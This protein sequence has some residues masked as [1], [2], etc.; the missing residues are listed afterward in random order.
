MNR[1]E[2]HERIARLTSA[3]LDGLASKE[4][5]AELNDRLR[6]DPDACE[7][8]LDLVETHAA[9]LHGHAGD[10]VA[11]Q[12]AA[13]V[14]LPKPK[15]EPRRRNGQGRTAWL[16]LAAS[17]VFL[18]AALSALW[19]NGRPSGVPAGTGEPTTE[20]GIAVL[21]RL[22]EPEWPEPALAH[23]EGATLV[24]GRFSLRSGLAQVEFFSGASLIVEGPAELELVDAWLVSCRSGRLR[25]SVP[26]PARGFTIET[27]DYR[28]VDLGTEF[29]L[30]VDH[31]GRSEVHVIEGEV[32]LDDHTGGE[33]RRLLT[34][35]GVR[36][37]ND[38]SGFEAVGRGGIDF[39]SRRELLTLAEDD[40]RARH[41]AWTRSR[42]QWN[43][44]SAP[45]A[46]FDFEGQDP[47]DRQLVN[48]ATDGADGAIIGAPWT[49]GR[50]PG[51][52]ALEFKRITDRVRVRIPGEFD[53]LT[54][55]TSVRIEGLDRWLSSLLLTDGFDPGEVHWQIS[56]EGELILGIA[57][58]EPEI[59]SFSPSVIAPRDL[60]RWMHL[61][62][63]I[64]RGNGLVRHY[65]DGEV[66][67]ERVFD[68]L[69]PLRI[70]DAEIGN[71]RPEDSARTHSIRSF[72]GR[73]DEL[74]IF[75]RGLTAEEIAGLAGKSPR[76]ELA[77]R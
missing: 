43:A 69:P 64:D 15:T 28:A 68:R 30:A 72:N 7:I 31:D 48:R 54:L 20:A 8:Y 9:L 36:S 66:V 50:W 4:D 40:W 6:G 39:V 21:S 19:L 56:D 51:K 58:A 42:E 22:V 57:G 38:G 60:G 44:G 1:K 26:E 76:R 11:D 65:L 14:R 33:L 32:R 29:A 45:V 27:P 41:A 67:G 53:A 46:L 23:A 61:A 5:L 10:A 47:W 74:L 59:N 75:D 13:L 77:R 70:G 12:M 34:G 62:V 37:T 2:R 71:W 73:M 24:P 63:T 16:A 35:N 18:A 49:E 17:A 52:G 55:A 25:A 3:W